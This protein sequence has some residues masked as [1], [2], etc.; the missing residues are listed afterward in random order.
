MFNILVPVTIL[1]TLLSFAFSTWL[2][3]K[4][5]SP[6]T[7]TVLIST[8]LI[9]IIFLTT[10]ITTQDYIPG[11]NILTFLL[12]PATVALAVPV[13]RNREVLKENLLAIT[14]GLMTGVV[15]ITLSTVLLLKVFSLGRTLSIAMLPKSVTIPIAAGIAQLTGSDPTLTIAFV[16]VTG[17]IG[18]MFATQILNLVGVKDPLARGLALGTSIHGLG[19]IIALREGELQGAMAGVAMATAAIPTSLI[20]P[21]LGS[22]FFPR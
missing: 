1:L 12:N 3:K 14:L 20:V 19:T 8:I 15:G 6:W 16:L 5:P 4:Y 17:N 10:G 11:K 22:L 9:I 2:D 18:S 7:N 21:L 13:Y